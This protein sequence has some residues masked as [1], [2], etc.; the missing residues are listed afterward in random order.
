VPIGNYYNGG[1]GGSLGVAFSPDWFALVSK[2]DGGKGFFSNAPSGDTV[3]FFLTGVGGPMNVAGG[4]NTGFSFFYSALMDPA[5][6]TVWSGFNGTGT[7]LGSLTVHPNP[8]S[9]CGTLPFCN[10]TPVGISFAGTAESVDFSGTAQ[11]IAFDNMTVGS[12][13]PAGAPTAAPEPATMLLLG[14]GS[15]GFLSVHRKKLA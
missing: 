1:A 13:T 9:S 4:F 10:W 11:F 5:T 3:A 6:V 14:V 2:L 8:G 7:L 15:L 12:A